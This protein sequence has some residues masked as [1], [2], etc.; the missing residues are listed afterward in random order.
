MLI[1]K[2]RSFQISLSRFSEHLQWGRTWYGSFVEFLTGSTPVR[3]QCENWE[4]LDADFES[5]IWG[6]QLYNHPIFLR[7]YGW[8]VHWVD[9]E[10]EQLLNLSRE[11][12]RASV[13]SSSQLLRAVAFLLMSLI[14]LKKHHPR[15]S[16]RD[17]YERMYQTVVQRLG[18]SPYLIWGHLD[19]VNEEEEERS[20]DSE[21]AY[22]F[23][24]KD[25]YRIQSVLQI[26]HVLVHEKKVQLKDAAHVLEKTGN[27]YKQWC[28]RQSNMMPDSRYLTMVGFLYTYGMEMIDLGIPMSSWNTVLSQ[29]SHSIAIRLSPVFILPHR[30]CSPFTLLRSFILKSNTPMSR[31]LLE[32][33][34]KE[35]KY[36]REEYKTMLYK[37]TLIPS[38]II[39]HITPFI[40]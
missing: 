35:Q 23:M 18:E 7:F 6:K 34:K 25:P 3:V 26:L 1:G 36:A 21:V 40:I 38:D 17:K 31:D 27:L 19:E 16:A 28:L 4:T 10:H 13:L 15:S 5:W 39:H 12:P 29:S 33:I 9:V 32:F 14:T 8:M 11:G 22:W 37:T 30:M 2:T 20:E 24:T